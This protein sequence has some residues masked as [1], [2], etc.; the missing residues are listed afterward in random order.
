MQLSFFMDLVNN[1]SR[2]WTLEREPNQDDNCRI[3]TRNQMRSTISDE[4]TNTTSGLGVGH[5]FQ[6]AF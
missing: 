6:I 5:V 3:L 1:R 4:M 2:K